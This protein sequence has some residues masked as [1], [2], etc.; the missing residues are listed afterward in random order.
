MF[1]FRLTFG[2]F[3]KDNTSLIIFVEYTSINEICSF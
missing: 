1:D 3:E 2:V